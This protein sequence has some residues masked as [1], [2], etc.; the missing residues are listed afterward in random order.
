M[1]RIQF[2]V[3]LAGAIGV[4]APTARADDALRQ[5]AL[6][7]NDVTGKDAIRGLSTPS[8]CAAGRSSSRCMT[9]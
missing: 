8:S 4:L 2:A 6:R 1:G 9:R 3:I 5:K 7:L